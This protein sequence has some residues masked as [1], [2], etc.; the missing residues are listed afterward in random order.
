M[1]WTLEPQGQGRNCFD[2]EGVLIRCAL[3]V[4]SLYSLTPC[5]DTESCVTRVTF[6]L[7]V[8]DVDDFDTN[9]ADSRHL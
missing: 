3:A 6:T 5:T 7:K 2:Q 4:P 1:S 9:R 8:V